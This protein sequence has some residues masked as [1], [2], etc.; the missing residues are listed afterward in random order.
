MK[1]EDTRRLRHIRKVD[2]L[3]CKLNFPKQCEE[4]RSVVRR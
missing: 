2:M 1:A 4:A 3:K